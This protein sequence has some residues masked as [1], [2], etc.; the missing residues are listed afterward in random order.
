MSETW[1][2]LGSQVGGAKAVIKTVSGRPGVGLAQLV[3]TMEIT[4][5]DDAS[6][7][8]PLW[9]HGRVEFLATGEVSLPLA[10]LA[11]YDQ[12][13][14]LR[15]RGDETM[16]TLTADIDDRQLQ[17]IE[18]NRAGDLRLRIW[19]PGHTIREGRVEP[20]HTNSFDYAIPQS[21]GIT[22]LEQV[23]YT[24]KFRDEVDLGKLQLQPPL[25]E[26]YNYYLEA[27]TRYMEGQ[28]RH[29][30]ESLRQCLAALV[31]KKPEEEDSATDFANALKTTKGKAY[32]TEVA[33]G[34]RFEL[35]RQAAKFLC[36][37]AAHPGSEETSRKHA[38][39]AL[40]L[41]TGLIESYRK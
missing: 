32:T 14:I 3:F 40:V 18:D 13:P 25:I 20:F 8:C 1:L 17:V 16:F 9:F 41:V 22:I 28:W 33:Y 36:D 37:L 27:R 21:Q 24:K 12:V 4:T 2:N 15:G 35:V 6:R 34:E 30:V 5:K 11:L 10:R 38:H 23:G 31:G 19:L 39:A 7:D 29:C 26:A